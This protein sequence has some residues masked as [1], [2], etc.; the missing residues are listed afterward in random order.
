MPR[1]D[2]YAELLAGWSALGGPIGRG[3]L[4]VKLTPNAGLFA[5]AETDFR[6]KHQV[7]AGVRLTW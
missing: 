3:E 1:R 6:R 7:G 5:T 2:S 4:G